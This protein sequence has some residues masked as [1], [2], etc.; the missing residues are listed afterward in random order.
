MREFWHFVTTDWYF[1]IPMFAMSLVS[2]TL[3]VWR[4]LLNNKANTN[5]NA[6]LPVF[7]EKLEK[8]G[9]DGALR[10]C[11]SQQGLIPRKLYVAGLETS[12][13]GLAAV[14]RGMANV[15]EL[16]IL[17]DLNFLLAPILAI[18]KIATMVG[19]LGT[20]ISMI[21]TFAKMQELRQEGQNVAD[22]GG[23]IG[24]ALFAT[25]LGLTIAI[26]LVF[27][28]VLF[29]AW[30]ANFEVRMKSAAQKLMVMLQAVRPSV[31]GPATP[32]N[33]RAADTA[34]APRR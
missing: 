25:A 6:F 34:V 18:A 11:Q 8:E 26:P 33:S 31:N 15:M 10:Y 22:L 7:Q 27:S 12:K 4:I 16:E 19:L 21:G 29:K 28:H 14:R 20:V 17:P 13:Q 24:L 32:A 30:I 5:L 2:I 23:S 9:V 1:A 3:V